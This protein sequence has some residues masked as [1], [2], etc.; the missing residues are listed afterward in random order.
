MG[1]ISRVEA[2]PAEC[3]ARG[4]VPHGVGNRPRHPVAP[5]FASL[6]R[7]GSQGWGRVRHRRDAAELLGE[8]GPAARRAR[9]G[10]RARRA[11]QTAAQHAGRTPG[12]TRRSLIR[13]PTTGVEIA[14]WDIAAR[15]AGV[16]LHRLLGNTCR[17]AVAFSE[18][19]APPRI[20]REETPTAIAAY[21]ARMVEEHDSHVFEGK[22]AVAAPRRRRPAREGGS[23]HDRA[24]SGAPARCE[25][26]LA[27]RHGQTRAGAAGAVRHRERRGACRPRSRKW[28]SCGARAQFRFSAHT[29]DVEAARAGSVLPTLSCRARPFGGIAGT[30][31]SSRPVRKPSSASGS[32]AATSG[33]RLLPT[34]ILR[35]RPRTSTARASRCFA[36]RRTT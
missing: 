33:F 7:T 4:D 18:Y 8:L 14:L 12:A 35:P 29:P 27:A 25:H 13:E 31:G 30:C 22:V 24:R 19:F 10:R 20:G 2:W 16:P 28:P 5:S 1:L 17:T 3:S 32:T 9:H 15:E 11:R 26:G 23:G 34:C 6:P 36:G 21:C